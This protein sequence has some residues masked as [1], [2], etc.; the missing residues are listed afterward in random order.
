MLK[1]A[2]SERLT[3]LAR[4]LLE[5]AR[6]SGHLVHGPTLV[7]GTIT[8]STIQFEICLIASYLL[9][10]SDKEE[11]KKL[12]ILGARVRN[13]RT[14]SPVTV[15]PSYFRAPARCVIYNVSDRVI[16]N[17]VCAQF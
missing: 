6:I 4:R 12:R 8:E 17:F 10:L 16:I 13:I 2:Y 9:V 5:F 1:H 14:V 7:H 3:S 15:T 11:E